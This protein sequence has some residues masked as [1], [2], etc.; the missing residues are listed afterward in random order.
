[1]KGW[2]TAKR[3]APLQATAVHE[4]AHAVA[5]VILLDSLSHV[6]IRPKVYVDGIEA[7]GLPERDYQQILACRS[8]EKLERMLESGTF[9]WSKPGTRVS[10]LDGVCTSEINTNTL[11]QDLENFAICLWVATTAEE[12]VTGK[13]IDILS[14]HPD[15][16]ALTD[17]Q[18]FLWGCQH[19]G[20]DTTQITDL[21][22]RVIP[23]TDAFV[24]THWL[25]IVAVA[26]ALLT[27]EGLSG[28]E[29]KAILSAVPHTEAVET[30]AQV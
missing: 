28:N 16:P 20:L 8:S 19:V 25:Q 9:K 7:T 1:M 24:R 13:E 12:M 17:L 4:A 29:V 27:K 18:D 15:S 10:V 5:Y 2:K 14:T 11:Q 30:P 6:T 3:D 21:L 22:K 23:Q 26:N